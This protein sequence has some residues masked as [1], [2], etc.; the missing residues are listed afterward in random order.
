M[1]QT[2]IKDTVLGQS[3]VGYTFKTLGNLTYNYYDDEQCYYLGLGDN[4][5]DTPIK[6]KVIDIFVK[7]LDIGGIHLYLELKIDDNTLNGKIL[8]R[9]TNIGFN[10]P[11][12]QRDTTKY[13]LDPNNYGT[14]DVDQVMHLK[15]SMLELVE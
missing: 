4:N 11:Q 2:S 9:P 6:F 13:W 10:V 14:T 1:G 5:L 8:A 3:V 7:K 12:K 15:R